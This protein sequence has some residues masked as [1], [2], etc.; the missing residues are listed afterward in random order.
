[1]KIK[2]RRTVLHRIYVI[3]SEDTFR[4]IL[5]TPIQLA[6]LNET[7]KGKKLFLS[8]RYCHTGGDFWVIRTKDGL[9]SIPDP[10]PSVVSSAGPDWFADFVA[11]DLLQD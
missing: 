11:E 3:I 10:L 1:M 7:P 8:H 4:P 9:Q 5:V 2:N 6:H